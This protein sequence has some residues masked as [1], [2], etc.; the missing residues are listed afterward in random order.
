MDDIV[1][2]ETKDRL[3]RSF[4]TG[5]RWTFRKIEKIWL[6]DKQHWYKE[7]DIVKVKYFATFGAYDYKDRW[8]DYWDMGPEIPKPENWKD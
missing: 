5:D 6:K 8:I 4:P 7:G 3:K 2:Q 1:T